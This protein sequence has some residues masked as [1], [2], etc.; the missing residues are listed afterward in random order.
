M[1]K[2]SCIAGGKCTRRV[3]KHVRIVSTSHRGGSLNCSQSMFK[4][5]QRRS[6][7]W[8]A[9]HAQII[10]SLPACSSLACVLKKKQEIRAKIGM[11]SPFSTEMRSQALAVKSRIKLCG[12]CSNQVD[13]AP[14]PPVEDCARRKARSNRVNVARW[15]QFEPQAKHVRILETSSRADSTWHVRNMAAS[16]S[17]SWGKACSNRVRVA[18]LVATWSREP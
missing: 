6:P 8:S 7:A 9:K 13:V 3:V 18:A 4:L 14:V 10:S 17:D 1:S 16:H 15:L 2:S 11:C 12:A 5:R